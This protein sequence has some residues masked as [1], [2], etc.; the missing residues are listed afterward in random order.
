VERIGIGLA[1]QIQVVPDDKIARLGRDPDAG[2]LEIGLAA[3]F[4]GVEAAHGR[5][6]ALPAD[7]FLRRPIRLVG[8]EEV[9]MRLE[10]LADGVALPLQR[11]RKR[12]REAEEVGDAMV[13]L[14]DQSIGRSQV[15]GLAGAEFRIR[16]VGKQAGG[17]EILVDPLDQPLAFRRREKAADHED[18]EPGRRDLEHAWPLGER[19]TNNFP[20][21][22]QIHMRLP[23]AEGVN[24]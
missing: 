4:H 13:D 6:G 16:L 19:F 10:L 15:A 22:P 20:H 1:G 11:F 3:F 9:V 12:G 21:L 7:Q 18:F 17:V 5:P 8:V 23:F 24:V 2:A 14:V